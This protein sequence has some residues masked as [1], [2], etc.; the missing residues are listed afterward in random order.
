MTEHGI[1]QVHFFGRK[2][3]ALDFALQQFLQEQLADTRVAHNLT[4]HEAVRQR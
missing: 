3:D 2:H 4:E 1:A